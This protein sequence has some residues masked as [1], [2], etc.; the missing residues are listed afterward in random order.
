VYIRMSSRYSMEH[1]SI[2]DCKVL[3]IHLWNA[4]GPLVSPKGITKYL[5]VP[6]F[7]LNVVFHS[8]R[9]FIL[10]LW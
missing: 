8:Y 3:L 5:Y 2:Y 10:T 4:T 1:M 9:A 7:I 6:Y